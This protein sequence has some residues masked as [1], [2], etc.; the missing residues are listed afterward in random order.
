MDERWNWF[1]D[2]RLMRSAVNATV[3][4]VWFWLSMGLLAIH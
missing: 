3:F 1:I 4:V 2:N